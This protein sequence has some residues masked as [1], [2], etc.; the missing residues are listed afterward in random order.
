[1]SW[2]RHWQDREEQGAN[3]AGDL[4]HCKFCGG[5]KKA[6]GH[7]KDQ[8]APN[9]V[10]AVCHTCWQGRPWLDDK[11]ITKGWQRSSA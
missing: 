4:Y 10:G 7:F 8:A 5:D 2:Y 3:A 11:M 6:L 1:M 9:G